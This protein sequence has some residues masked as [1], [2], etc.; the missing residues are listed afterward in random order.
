MEILKLIAAVFVALI[1]LVGVVFLTAVL[2]ALADIAK[3]ENDKNH[4]E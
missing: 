4:E 1:L 2:A 3:E